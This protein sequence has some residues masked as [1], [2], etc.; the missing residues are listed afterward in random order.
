MKLHCWNNRD[1]LVD[2][3]VDNFCFFR[4]FLLA[5]V[6]EKSG[7]LDQDQIIEKPDLEINKIYVTL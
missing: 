7:W 4:E 5:Q 6:N 2:Y 1:V 3:K